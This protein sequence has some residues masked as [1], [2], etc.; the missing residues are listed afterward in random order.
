[1]PARSIR[2]I[3]PEAATEHQAMPESLALFSDENGQF[4]SLK[5]VAELRAWSQ[6]TQFSRAA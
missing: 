1:M 6:V 2:C 5:V 4:F 3:S